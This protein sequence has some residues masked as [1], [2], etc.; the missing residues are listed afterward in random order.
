MSLVLAIDIGG[1]KIAAGLVTSEGDVVE[2]RTTPT[3]RE[4][5]EVLCSRSST[6]SRPMCAASGAAV[7]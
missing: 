4:N 3:P 1:T 6:V 7:P 2:R 5:P